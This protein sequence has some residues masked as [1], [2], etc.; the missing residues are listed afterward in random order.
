MNDIRRKCL[1]ELLKERRIIKRNYKKENYH[2]EVKEYKKENIKS[3]YVLNEKLY[4]NIKNKGFDLIYANEIYDDKVILKLDRVINEHNNYERHLLVGELGSVNKYN[5]I[6]TDFSL[7]VV[8]SYTVALLN[9]LGVKRITL[10]YEMDD[11]QIKLLIDSYKNRY[12]KNPNLSII[13]YAKEEMM[14]SKFDLLSYYNITSGY[15]KDK[16]NNLYSL[17]SNNNLMYIYNYKARNL[18]DINKYYR[19]GINEVRYNIIDE[20]DLKNI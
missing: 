3:V 13:V 11:E 12:K 15:L 7:N 6:D 16:F 18:K 17:I 14:I 4:N 1:D 2:R 10:S 20:E 5:N 8:N 19:M 9:N